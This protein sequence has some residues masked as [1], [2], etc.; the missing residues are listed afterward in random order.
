MSE[1]QRL[2]S[3]LR[4]HV[5]FEPRTPEE[6]TCYISR[7]T[8]NVGL[9]MR[10]KTSQQIDFYEKEVTNLVSLFKKKSAGITILRYTTHKQF[11]LDLQVS[12]EQY[13]KSVIY[14]LNKRNKNASEFLY[15]AGYL[16]RLSNLSHFFAKAYDNFEEVMNKVAY[17][18]T[19]EYSETNRLLFRSGQKGDSFYIILKGSVAVL[20]PHETHIKMSERDYIRYLVKLKKYRE[21]DLY[22]KCLLQ[23]KTT[24]PIPDDNL[25]KYLWTIIDIGKPSLSTRA[26]CKD[27]AQECLDYLAERVDYKRITVDEYLDIFK[28]DLEQYETAAEINTVMLYEYNHVTNLEIGEKF[29]DIA[30]DGKSQ[31]RSATIITQEDSY[32][33]ILNKRVYDACVKDAILKVK[34]SNINMILNSA[35]FNKVISFEN[36]EKG[37][38]TNFVSK[39]FHQGLY[40]FKEAEK[41]KFL[42]FIK[43]GEFEIVMKK[44]IAELN[45]IIQE[46][47][48]H[49]E[50]RQERYLTTNN[51]EFRKLFNE[52]V[53][54]R[55][56]IIKDKE[57][58][59]L[60]DMILNDK[61]N[62]SVI[63]QS[64]EGEAIILERKFF[65]ML[66]IK[67]APMV[68]NFLKVAKLKNKIMLDKIV[69]FKNVRMKKFYE[70]DYSNIKIQREIFTKKKFIPKKQPCVVLKS[71]E[72]IKQEDK[73]EEN[74][75]EAEMVE[76]NAFNPRTT[77]NLITSSTFEN[78]DTKTEWF[79]K[80][81]EP[82]LTEPTETETKYCLTNSNTKRY[83]TYTNSSNEDKTNIRN[84]SMYDVKLAKLR[85]N[86]LT[87]SK[88]FITTTL[89]HNGFKAKNSGLCL[90][91]IINLVDPLRK[92]FTE[93]TRSS[94]IDTIYEKSKLSNIRAKSFCRKMV[95]QKN[96]LKDE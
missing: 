71:T 4:V 54:I 41:P 13:F 24:Y 63:C 94:K 32:F 45:L 82:A 20:V 35:L 85:F 31:K 57:I 89:Q 93:T 10:R 48:G 76:K 79:E 59:G 5:G 83:Y 92:G 27:S 87:D 22:F 53:V 8:S 96:L 42:Y 25:E 37:Y 46:L 49:I 88:E 55:L 36:F 75:E 43:E 18:M 68:E 7:K 81:V 12:E 95:L 6:N 44:S 34:K 80:F 70:N 52:K 66:L 40:V 3:G 67:E 90:P 29:G 28:L 64:L 58:L 33:G 21:E 86:T 91:S 50:E 38:Y 15:I 65:D 11:Y 14:L 77:T 69:N 60:S 17:Q 39:K 47:G 2:V 51:P 62:C 56:A 78:G 84:C 72:I 26:I 30:L 73:A 74:F 23:N 19:L 9:I 61:F 1:L 16:F